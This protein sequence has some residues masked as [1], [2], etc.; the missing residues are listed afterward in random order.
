MLQESNLYRVTKRP[1]TKNVPTHDRQIGVVEGQNLEDIVAEAL[2]TMRENGEYTRTQA[3][4][5]LRYARVWV[6]GIPIR[7]RKD[8]VHIFPKRGAHIHIYEGVKGGGGGGGGKS[9]IPII[10][11]IV[12]SVIA[13]WAG[14]VIAGAMGFAT[15]GIVAGV[16]GLGLTVAGTYALNALFPQAQP[17]LG[18][19]GITD[20]GSQSQ[21]YAISGTQNSAN[22][23]GYIPVV[24][25]KH[26]FT[27][28]LGAKSWTVW[29]G[30]KQYFHMLVV[31]G[32]A[33]LEVSDFRIEQTPLDDF[34]HVEHYH[35]V[36]TGDNLKLFAKTYN[37]NSVGAELSQTVGWVTRTVGEAEDISIDIQ[38]QQLFSVNSGNGAVGEQSVTFEIQYKAKN[39]NV[40]NSFSSGEVIASNDDRDLR[41]F[42]YRINDLPKNTYEVR[43][44]RVSE[45]T[46]SQ[47]IYDKATWAVM[48]A[49]NN[50][51]AFSSTVPILIS[52]LRI[53]A[54]E[55]LSG[56][57][58]QFNGIAESKCRDYIENGKWEYRKTQNPSSLA[59]YALTSPHCLI[60]PFDD[61]KIDFPSF[62]E[63]HT[64]CKN[65]KY[66]FNFIA[67][68]ETTLWERLVQILSIGRGAPTTDIDGKWGV[69]IDRNGK[70]VKQL[71]TPRNSWGMKYNRT[72][73]N[74]P[75]ALRVTFVD[76]EN[77]YTQQEQYVC[78]D[79][80]TVDT[81][82]EPHKKKA[83]DI[84]PYDYP[85]VVT[86]GHLHPLARR[87]LAK[88]RHRQHSLSTSTDWEWLAVR[89]GDLVAVSSDSLM[90]TFG[91]AYIQALIYDVDGQ[92]II[93]GD[94]DNIPKDE[95][96]NF[97][98]PVGLQLDDT[99]VFSE[100]A[101]AR[102]GI[103][104]R[105]EYGRVSGKADYE[106]VAEYG[107]EEHQD[108]YFKYPLHAANVP[109]I[110]DLCA[111]S[112][113][114]EE[115]EEFLF[116]SATPGERATCEMSLIPYA[117][118]ELD[119]AENGP[120]PEFKPPVILDVVGGAR[121][122][123]PII[124]NIKSDEDVLVRTAMGTSPTIKAWAK[125]PASEKDISKVV[126]QI[127]AKKEG[128]TYAKTAI[129]QQNQSFV[130]IS[131]VEEKSV[132]S[133]R[134]RAIDSYSGISSDWS[135]AVIHKVIGRT[136]PPPP[137]SA[138]LMD[139][140][141]IHIEQQQKPLDFVGHVVT[142]GMDETD[143]I[144]M[145]KVVTNPYTAEGRFDL[146]SYIGRARKIYVQAIDELGLTSTPVFI[147]LN[148]GD[149]APENILFQISEQERDWSGEVI[150]GFEQFADL[151]AK[152]QGT[153]YEQDDSLPMY[154][155]NDSF[156]RYAIDD[157]LV[158]QYSYTIRI[159]DA[160]LGGKLKV[161]PEL[162][163][164][165]I[166]NFEY[167]F[168][169]S[170]P[171]YPQ[172]NSLSMYRQRSGD[173]F[174]PQVIR[175]EWQF[176]PDAYLVSELGIMEI[177][178]TTATNPQCIIGDI[179]TIIDV[180]DKTLHI[181]D[182]QV[183]SDG[184]SRIPVPH[185]YFRGI[186]NV[187]ITQQYVE[188]SEAVTTEYVKG[189]EIKDSNYVVE[190]QL[191]YALDNNKQR[192]SANVDLYILGY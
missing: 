73:A 81:A 177:R 18:K 111:V 110:G 15:T 59:L 175:T 186:T 153:Y 97:L 50:V 143:V 35:H 22:P 159:L 8:W 134:V 82:A 98:I 166:T 3:R 30:D 157:G 138:V 79:G 152:T 182:M 99:V 95:E 78:W 133:I 76:A 165:R 122:P 83:T 105:D 77:G 72:F 102:Y 158:M 136:T 44:R 104:I 48:R 37:E 60:K 92:E 184:T 117:A 178:V 90:N 10:G 132:Y 24:F 192:T 5:L 131:D 160:Y 58:S 155:Q 28:P 6:D 14:G 147:L 53:Q 173:V 163:S 151:Y 156:P 64:F 40:W 55:Q 129:G 56:Y 148:I 169:Q 125:I 187:Q 12:L 74:M 149:I 54:S 19:I 93:V 39:T 88:L 185:G 116:A 183:L 32:Q 142:V 62:Q 115:Y 118:N 47:Y 174:Y 101:P 31:W 86:W 107:E 85:G 145:G 17:K 124:I 150:N 114:G 190:G 23:E 176:L 112:L 7:N 70:Q 191:I 49:I 13:P 188:G 161:I 91:N 1:W 100:P 9:I 119:A 65:K 179:K 139:G 170:P 27:P 171:R 38:F 181:N 66:T 41:V 57:V 89:R 52:E 94:P 33:D 84:W 108:L 75:H 67:D 42:N 87:H 121:L 25:G 120:I 141:V 164:G 63:F 137:P 16:I 45:D 71:F 127:S 36:T 168:L 2:R 128:M 135:A 140:T 34:N 144:S 172:E 189:S 162:I 29:E 51:P 109:N 20:V 146:A 106:L 123:T 68:T 103:A 21:A 80:Y 43:I 180:E 61:K 96:G 4:Q 26:R 46:D 113:L 154:S 167:R 130:S 11:M 69:I 126:Y